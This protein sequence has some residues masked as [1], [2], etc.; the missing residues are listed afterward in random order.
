MTGWG[1]N[2]SGQ[3]SPC[4]SNII[5]I[6]ASYS[7]SLYLLEGGTVAD[8]GMFFDGTATPITVPLGLSNVVAISAGWS[9]SLALKA[10]RTVVAWGLNTY[11]QTDIP[12]GLTNVAA[13][14]SG[15][16]HSLALKTD[17]TLVGWG[18]GGTNI[19]GGMSNVVAI[20][21][22]PAGNNLALKADGTAVGW[23][24]RRDQTAAFATLS[25]IVSISAGDDWSYESWLALKDNGDVISCS[26]WTGATSKVQS[27]T[28]AIACS[29][30]TDHH[31]S[32]ALKANGTVTGWGYNFY[33]GP[34]VPVGLNNVVAIAAGAGHQ[35]ALVGG[36]APF[37]QNRL[38]DRVAVMGGKAF[39][40]IEATGARPL[41][42][43]WKLFGTNL[44]G[45]T[46]ALLALNNLQPN[47]AGSYSV[48]VSNAF[49]GAISE[50]AQLTLT[51]MEITQ[52]PT[53][54]TNIVGTTA[55]F[56]VEVQALQPIY[57]QWRREGVNIDGATNST[58]VLDNVQFAHAGAY[59]VVAGNAYGTIVSS[60]AILTVVPIL[61]TTQPQ[62]T[63]VFVGGTVNLSVAAQGALPFSYQWQFNDTDL[64][65]ATNSS[66][67]LVN[68]QRGQAGRYHVELNNPLGTVESRDARLSVVAIAAW[69]SLGQTNVPVD[70]TNVNAIAAGL[71]HQLRLDHNGLVTAWGD[72]SRTNIP[73]GLS[74][75]VA[76][77]GGCYADGSLALKDD[78][79]VVMWGINSY[80]FSANQAAVASLTN[81]VATAG[82]QSHML[83]L[84]ANGTV[85]AWGDN[86]VRQLNVPSDL[87]NA[88]AL[89]AGQNHSL[90]LKADGTV[91]A[92]GDN[93]KGQTN[94]PSGLINA[95]AVAAGSE[96]SLALRDDGTVIVWGG[97]AFYGQARLPIGLT[98]VVAIGAGEYHTLALKADGTVV[99]WNYNFNGETNIPTGLTNVVAIA[100][101]RTSMALVGDGPPIQ[102]VSQVNPTWSS[103][104][105]SVDVPTQSGRVYRLEYKD[106]PYDLNWKALP[107]VAGNGGVRTLVDSTAT[108][109]QRFYRVRQW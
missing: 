72:S 60:N 92:W 29:I 70:S 55:T 94:V 71:H 99:G 12:P 3:I 48:T 95:V 53:N 80:G 50:S 87:T 46:S 65:E 44:P 47:Q 22:G 102:R 42:Y 84:K 98:N 54:R 90:G 6:S 34:N 52:Q 61:I 85:V 21:A 63:I 4:A 97:S 89:A 64:I 82:G 23:G 17:G 11:G 75:V 38:L 30:G 51:P 19:P 91:K 10:D 103:R 20:S 56:N 1:G 14:A 106:T 8:C 35:L 93:S 83:A 45:A 78:G 66:L 41:S 57:Y 81:V 16:L 69:G 101:S 24:F 100:A 25:N 28:I 104:G 26:P 13:I 86:T 18:R 108:S 109:S 79:T 76:I 96:H 62:D 68:V 33:G 59:S 105:F 58:L 88:V 9:H 74:N 39:F 40:R 7:H 5:A 37:I 67:A 107:L 31:I 77:S 73:A 15:R 43:Q 49:G 2:E 36:G 32:L 27:N